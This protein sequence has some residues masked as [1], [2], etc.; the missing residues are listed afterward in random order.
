VPLKQ[1]QPNTEPTNQL[2]NPKRT[3]HHS[4]ENSDPTSNKNNQPTAAPGAESVLDAAKLFRQGTDDDSGGRNQNRSR[5]TGAEKEAALRDLPLDELLLACLLGST[6]E[7][8]CLVG[9]FVQ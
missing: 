8:G 1:S 9:W 3:T 6:D 7:G 2:T 5:I 4:T